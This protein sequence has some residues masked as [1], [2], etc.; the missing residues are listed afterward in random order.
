MADDLVSLVAL[1]PFSAIIQL[2]M[3][4]WGLSMKIAY[5]VPR[6]LIA[7]QF[8]T[9]PQ[10]LFSAFA[11]GDVTNRAGDQHPFL[12]FERT[13]TDFGWKFR[14]VPAQPEKFQT[15]AP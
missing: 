7:G 13:E 4:P 3:C 1:E 8:F 5:P 9:L 11:L 14:S 2:S 15:G 10:F 12:G 6:R